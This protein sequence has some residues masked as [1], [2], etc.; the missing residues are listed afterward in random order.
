MP[1]AEP[2][3]HATLPGFALNW[4]N[5]FLH[6]L[7]LRRARH[8][9]DFILAGEARDRRDLRQVDGRLVAEDGADHH[10]AADHHRV[11][12]ALA[13]AYELR[14]AD[15]AAGAALVVDRD[16]LD[17]VAALQR[18]LQRA[19]G[20]IPAAAG[21]RGHQ[22]FQAVDSAVAA[23]LAIS[24]NAAATNASPRR[25]RITLR[26]EPFMIPPMWSNCRSRNE[27]DSGR[28]RY[29]VPLVLVDRCCP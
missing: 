22:D 2:P 5:E 9:D 25:A 13:R 24:A 23:P 29:A 17:D 21:R 11:R 8:D 4:R 12:I 1:P 15:R 19:A 10:H 6:R 3:P 7:Y 16:F 26:I 14:K 27:P 18:R 28:R 20:L